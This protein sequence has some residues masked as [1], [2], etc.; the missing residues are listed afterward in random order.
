M[1]KVVVTKMATEEQCRRTDW[2]GTIHTALSAV[3]SA[4]L[5]G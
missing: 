5:E 1:M 3:L 4:V 2:Q